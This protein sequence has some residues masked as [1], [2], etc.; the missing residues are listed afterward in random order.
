MNYAPH[1]PCRFFFPFLLLLALLAVGVSA[2]AQGNNAA[3]RG[4]LLQSQTQIPTTGVG[5]PSGVDQNYAAASPNDSD[6]GEQAILKRAEKYQPFT[7]EVGSPFY[8]TSN[9]ALVDRG[10]VDD[11][12][13]APVVGL[14]YAPKFSKTLY[15]DFSIRQQFFF[16]NDNTGFD[17]ASFD[18]LAGLVYYVPRLHNLT[19]RANFDYNRL[20]GTHNFDSFF[21]NYAL[22]FS[23]E[24]P[25]P[26]G[27][28]QQISIGTDANI[29]L[30]ATPNPPQR[31]D[32][33]AYVGYAVN[34]SRSFSLD[35]A[36]RLVVRPYYQGS[37]TDVS[38]VIALSA[39]YRIK[40]YLTLSAIST[41][42]ANQSSRSVFDYQ[43][44]NIGGG[45]SLTWRF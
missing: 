8:Y 36:A 44:F 33:G 13:I 5:A 34:V 23:A 18:V 1:S 32:F 16:Y 2:H 7:I 42:V 15:G 35:A 26:I 6:L 20:T 30:Y 28:A 29:S 22:Q 21:E 3:D 25:I 43:V 41:F 39:N 14:T 11:V 38:E 12:I 31:G 45:V 40:D 37:R 19:L 10:K 9:V 17:F 27:R 4:R 24:V